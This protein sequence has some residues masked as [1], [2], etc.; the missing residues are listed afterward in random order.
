MAGALPKGFRPLTDY[1]PAVV[2][3]LSADVKRPA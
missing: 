1:R 2:A 3:V